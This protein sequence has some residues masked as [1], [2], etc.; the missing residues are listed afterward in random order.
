MLRFSILM[1]AFFPVF[2]KWL[3]WAGGR[4]LFSFFFLFCQLQFLSEIR[5]KKKK[6]TGSQRLFL[7]WARKASCTTL[8]YPTKFSFVFD[9]YFPWNG[10]TEQ[11]RVLEMDKFRLIFWILPNTNESRWGQL[12]QPSCHRLWELS[13]RP[14]GSCSLE[15][16][17][18]W[19]CL[20]HNQQGLWVCLRYFSLPCFYS[21]AT[22]NSLRPYLCHIISPIYI[23][24]LFSKEG[25]FREVDCSKFYQLLCPLFM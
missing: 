3:P 2:P 21:F 1:M 8:F 15:L 22:F 16:V 20:G 7:D 25:N 13:S 19:L 10:P 6:V 23:F 9:Q 14:L 11:G 12:R 5:K 17:Q 18:W 24:Y 4:S